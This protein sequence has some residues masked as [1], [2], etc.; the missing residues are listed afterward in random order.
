MPIIDVENLTDL[1]K[2]KMEVDQKKKEILLERAM[3]S[4]CCTEFMELVQAG[5]DEDPLVKGI[6]EDK[7]PFKE[8]KGGC[9]IC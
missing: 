2:A 3:T 5:A 7:N 6:P 9:V 8:I 4:K 1:E